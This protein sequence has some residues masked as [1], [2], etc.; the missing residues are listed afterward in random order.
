MDNELAITIRMKKLAVLLRDARLAAGRLPAECATALGVALEE[1]KRYENGEA[2]PSLPELEALAYY[3]DVPASHF[4]GSRS[5]SESD[6]GAAAADQIAQSLAMRREA[7]GS[8]LASLREARGKTIGELSEVT[9][10]PAGELES[11][12]SGTTAVPAPRLEVLVRELDGSL[13]DFTGGAGPVGDWIRA[14]SNIGQLLEM[15]AELQEFVCKPFNRP[16]LEIAHRLS[17]ME[18][19]KLRNVAEGILEITL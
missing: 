12:E 11:Y 19:N 17:T 4:W 1:Y 13:Q 2:A 15:P 6:S 3:L 10:I 5:L 18:V 14:R 16:Y 7:I 9:G 8:A